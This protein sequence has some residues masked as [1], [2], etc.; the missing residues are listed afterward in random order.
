VG[1]EIKIFIEEGEYAQINWLKKQHVPKDGVRGRTG[2]GDIG[3]KET[4]QETKKMCTRGPDEVRTAGQKELQKGG[5]KTRETKNRE[6]LETR[7]R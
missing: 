4:S 1:G 3:G 7:K 2:I 5:N 6:L